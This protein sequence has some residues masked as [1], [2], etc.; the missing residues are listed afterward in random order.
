[1]VTATSNR[2][3]SVEMTE[4][5]VEILVDAEIEFDVGEHLM[6]AQNVRRAEK[7]RKADEGSRILE[8]EV[9]KAGEARAGVL[10]RAPLN[11]RWLNMRPSLDNGTA[12]SKNEFVDAARLRLGLPLENLPKKCDGCGCDF[13]G[14]HGK[15]CKT[16]GLIIQRHDELKKELGFLLSSALNPSAIRDEPEIYFSQNFQEG[17]ARGQGIQK[18]QR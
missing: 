1:M 4:H 6:A 18:R 16:G 2:N 13:D 5:L 11:G 12:L 10:K 15:N 9:V 8:A 17:E 3:A 14:E 7:E